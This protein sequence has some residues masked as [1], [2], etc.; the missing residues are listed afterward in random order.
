MLFT[1][2]IMSLN[3]S[4]CQ[5]QFD[6]FLWSRWTTAMADGHF[7]YTLDDMKT[8]IVPGQRAYVLQVQH[9]GLWN[10]LILCFIYNFKIVIIRDRIATPSV[11]CLAILK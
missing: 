8:R 4:I 11:C 5:L 6:T 9:T 2:T 3:L 1:F 7:K 10:F